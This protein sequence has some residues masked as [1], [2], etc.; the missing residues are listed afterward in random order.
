[1]KRKSSERLKIYPHGGVVEEVE[2]L[3]KVENQEKVKNQEE[4]ED[5]KHI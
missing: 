4:L 5:V 2:N 1:M 3:E